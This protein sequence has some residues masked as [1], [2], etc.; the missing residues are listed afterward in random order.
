MLPLSHAR[1]FA[2]EDQIPFAQDGL[3]AVAGDS[4]PEVGLVPLQ[5]GG[6]RRLI[7]GDF[8]EYRA[9]VSRPDRAEDWDLRQ[10]AVGEGMLLDPSARGGIFQRPF[11][12][13]EPGGRDAEMTGQ[14]IQ[15][16]PA[17]AGRVA[18]FPTHDGGL[19]HTDQRGDLLERLARGETASCRRRAVRKD[20]AFSMVR[21]LYPGFW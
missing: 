17:D 8:L 10:S 1:L 11:L 6:R 7:P 12:A 13:L 4:Q 14:Q 2:H 15:G 5:G 19:V 16:R 3:H 9:A 20:V 18:I 21:L